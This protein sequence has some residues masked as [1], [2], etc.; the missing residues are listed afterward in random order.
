MI[1]ALKRLNGG[2][3]PPDD[4]V[5]NNAIANYRF[6]VSAVSHLHWRTLITHA[7]PVTLR[8][9][10]PRSGATAIANKKFF[11]HDASLTGTNQ[12]ARD[13]VARMRTSFSISRAEFAE[14][15][16]A[17]WLLCQLLAEQ[18]LERC[19]GRP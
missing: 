9:I 7:T 13:P 16:I 8:V 11:N 12:L 14:H 4:D 1:G 3:F 18:D 19:W 17:I 15:S 5:V 2:A 10:Q 6:F